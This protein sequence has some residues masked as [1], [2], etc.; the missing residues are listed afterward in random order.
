M[1]R[2]ASPALSR[3]CSS[4]QV[5]VTILATGRPGAG[6]ALA[7]TPGGPSPS[8]S[9]AAKAV[10]VSIAAAT[11]TSAASNERFIGDD[12]TVR[13]H[14]APDPVAIQKDAYTWSRWK[15]KQQAA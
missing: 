9:S 1:T 13:K 2:S 7:G 3:D 10:G 12:Q 4:C 11:E 15:R 14:T 8:A 6:N 5:S